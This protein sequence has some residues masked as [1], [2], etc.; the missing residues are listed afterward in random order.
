MRGPKQLPVLH[1]ARAAL[2]SISQLCSMIITVTSL[3]CTGISAE[4]TLHFLLMSLFPY[5]H[6]SCV[7]N[8]LQNKSM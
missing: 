3:N 8:E 2:D 6:L 7:S 4:K 1:A 5:G